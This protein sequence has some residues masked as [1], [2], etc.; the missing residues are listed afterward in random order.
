MGKAEINS[1]TLDPVV[2]Q[3][4]LLIGLLEPKPNEKD[5]Y[6]LNDRWFSDPW[7]YLQKIPSNPQMFTLMTTLMGSAAGNA[8][9]TP[10]Q[11]LNRTW[12][13]IMNTS[14]VEPKATGL[15]IVSGTP[16]G[17][18]NPEMGIGALYT[19]KYDNDTFSV[20]PYAYFP[21]FTLPDEAGNGFGFVLG[22]PGHPVQTGVQV[23]GGNGFFSTGKGINNL[24]FDGFNAG[25][26]IFFSEGMYPQL[27]LVFQNLRLPGE[28]QGVNRS[29]VDLI[30]NTSIQQWIT[31]ALSVLGSQLSQVGGPLGTAG[32][33]IHTLLELLGLL[34]TVPPVNWDAI[35][36]NPSDTG[37]VLSQWIRNIAVNPDSLK[38]WLNTWY[39]L[40]TGQDSS[41]SRD[42]ITGTGTRQDPFAAQVL[43]LEVTQTVVLYFDIGFAAVTGNDL[44]LSF[45]PNLIIRSKP[46]LPVMG[47]NTF[48]IDI[49]AQVELMAFT[50]PPAALLTDAPVFTLFP[51]LSLMAAAASTVAGKPLFAVQ[52]PLADIDSEQVFSIDS[53]QVGFTYDRSPDA[54]SDVPVPNFNL[55]NVQSAIGAWPVINLSSFS[56]EAFVNNI[57]SIVSNAISSFFGEN[58]VYAKAF[59]AVLGIAAPA[60]YSGEWP[61]KDQL[62]LSASELPLLIAN[63]FN[64]LG[65][66]YTRCLTTT[67]ASGKPLFTYLVPDICALLGGSGTTVLG[68]GTA[69]DPWRITVLTLGSAAM[70]FTSWY[71]PGSPTGLS[72][73]LAFDV[74]LVFTGVT[75]TSV[76]YAEL[77]SLQLP[78]ADGSGTWGAAWMQSALTRL[79]LTGTSGQVLSTPAL[80]GVALQC[81]SVTGEAGWKNS[82]GFYAQGTIRELLLKSNSTSIPLGTLTLGTT[83]WSEEQLKQFTPAI[84]NGLGLLLLENGGR[85]G[86][87]NAAILGLL[88]NMPEVINGSG[89]GYD[90]PVP[91]LALPGNWPVLS[92]T[93]YSDPWTDVQTQ[94]SNL[95]AGGSAMVIPALRMLGWGLTGEL[96]LQPAAQ[97]GNLYDPWEVQLA[98]A[99]VPL[100][101]LTWISEGNQ[102]GYG[103][104]YPLAKSS[105]AGVSIAASVRLDLPGFDLTPTQPLPPAVADEPVKPR[106]V[107]SC[108]IANTDPAQPLLQDNTTGLTIGSVQLG[109]S[110]AVSGDGVVYAPVFVFLNS[111]L[112]TGDSPGT[113]ELMIDGA[114]PQWT[115][116]QGLLQFNQLVY[117]LMNKLTDT[118]KA[119]AFAQ[120]DSLMKLLA[121][122]RIVMITEGSA[123]DAVAPEYGFNPGGW[124]AML[125]NP[126]A[127]FVQQANLVLNDPALIAGFLEAAAGVLGISPALPGGLPQVMAALGLFEQYQESYVPDFKN[128]LS[129]VTNPSE[130][131]SVH[132]K[133]LFADAEKIRSLVT[134]ISAYAGESGW[135]SIDSSGQIVTIGIQPEDPYVIGDELQLSAAVEIDLNA[136][137]LSLK[138]AVASVT[139]GSALEF[140]YAPVY[141]DAEFS[142]ETRCFLTSWTDGSLPAAFPPLQV[143]PIPEDVTAI[144]TQLGIQAPVTLLSTFAAKYLNTF[145]TPQNPAVLNLFRV[146][147]LAFADDTQPMRIRPLEGIFMHPVQWMLSP[148]V[149]GNGNG[150]IDLTRLGNLLYAVVDAAGISSGS[151]KLEPYEHEGKRDGVKLTGLPWGVN[152][153]LNSSETEGVQL[154]ATFAPGFSSPLPEIQLSGG[155][156]YIPAHGLSVSGTADLKFDFGTNGS[157]QPVA[158]EIQ[159]AYSRNVFTLSAITTTAGDSTIFQLLPFAG[160]NQFISGISKVLLETVG[161]MLFA[162]YDAYLVKNPNSALK[163]FVGSIESLTGITSGKTLYEFFNTIAGDPLAPFTPARIEGTISGIYTFV[164]GILQLD[165]FS[166]SENGN[167]LEYLITFD[168]FPQAKILM[169]VGIQDIRMD[170]RT[171]SA[172]GIWVQPTAQFEWITLGLSGTGVGVETPFNL[173]APNLV[174]AANFTVGINPSAIGIEGMPSPVLLFGL[175]GDL[176]RVYGPA[177]R[178]FPVKLSEASG[179]L[180]IDLLPECKLVITGN[181]S[182]TNTQWMLSFG[183]NFLVPLVANMALST[184]TVKGWLDNTTI[185]TVKG[186]PGKVLTDWG[187]LVKTGKGNYILNNLQ[188]AFDV[189]QPATIVTKLIFC[190]LNLI[191]GQC[192]VPIGDK[193]IYVQSIQ[194]GDLTRYGLRLQIPDIIVSGDAKP[195]SMK[196]IF[197]LGKYFGKETK[198]KNWTGLVS[199]PGLA[200]YFISRNKA[201]ELSFWPRFDLVSIGL[202]FSGPNA[203]KPLVDLNGVSIQAVEPRVLVILDLLDGH[204]TTNFG[205]AIML[206]TIGIPLGPGFANQGGSTNPVAQNLLTSGGSSDQTDAVNPAFSASAGYVYNDNTFTFQL[207][208]PDGNPTD[209]VILP[210]M[211]AFGPLQCRKIGIGWEKTPQLLDILFDGSVSL[212]GL[213]ADVQDLKIGIPVTTPTQFD[214]YKLDL[215]GLDISFKSGAVLISG[216]F[217]KDDSLGFIQYIGQAQIRTAQWGLGAFGAYGLVEGNVSLFIFAYLNAPIGGPPYFFIKG[218]SG[219][220]GYNR[221][222]NLPRADE[223][224]RF[225]LIAGID[226]SAALGGKNGNP[227]TNTEALSALGTTIVPP[228]LGSYWLAAGIKFTSFELIDSQAML[229][230]QFGTD[231]MIGLLGLSGLVL[232]KSGTPYVGAQ[233]AFTVTY[234]VS[235]GLLAMEAVLTPNSYVLSRDCRLTGGMAFYVWFKDQADTGA[236]AGEFVFTL[237][238]YS[239]KFNKPAYFPDEPRLG[240]S[241]TV[242]DVSIKGGAYF[243]LTPSAVMAGGSLEAVYKSGELRAWFNAWADFLIMWKPFHFYITVGINVGASYT[244]HFIWT[245]TFKVELGA[246]LEL[247]GPQTAG[248]VKVKWWV[249]SFTVKFG[250][251]N[252]SKQG[253]RTIDWPQFKE[254]F[255]PKDQAPNPPPQQAPVPDG[256]T[257]VMAAGETPKVQQVT[258]IRALEGLL[259]E[260][261]DAGTTLWQVAADQFVFAVSTVAPLN[262]VMYDNNDQQKIVESN[263]EFGLR[264]LG[265]VTFNGAD[266]GK[267]S[268]LSVSILMNSVALPQTALNFTGGFNGV[269]YSLWGTVNNGS[270]APDSKIIPGALVGLEAVQVI[271]K[272][273]PAGPPKFPVSNF[274]LQP[275]P[276]RAL[277]LWN[278]PALHPAEPARHSP[279]SVIII[280]QTIMTAPVPEKRKAILEAVLAS[281]INVKTDGNLSMMAAYASAVFQSFPML[282][283]LGSLGQAPVQQ[284]SKR[285][286]YVNGKPARTRS[287]K[288]KST[289]T[290]SAPVVRAYTLQYPGPLLHTNVFM[291][292]SNSDVKQMIPVKGS[293]YLTGLLS[294]AEDHAMLKGVTASSANG[295]TSV[296]LLPGS[297]VMIDFNGEEMPA[298]V[299]G[300]FPVYCAFFDKNNQYLSS[301]VKQPGNTFTIS[302]EATQSLFFGIDTANLTLPYAY[303]WHSTTQ[304]IQVNPNALTGMGAII[305]PQ[306]PALIPA[307]RRLRDFGLIQGSAMLEQNIVETLDGIVNGSVLTLLPAGLKTV[308][309]LF[310][311]E[312]AVTEP[313]TDDVSATIAV[314]QDGKIS[315][316]PLEAYALV[317]GLY[318]NAVI[319]TLP[320]Q[321]GVNLRTVAAKGWRLTGVMALT[322]DAADVYTNWEAIVL[323]PPVPDDIDQYSEKTYVRLGTE[324]AAAT[325][326]GRK[327]K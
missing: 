262:Y 264:P 27:N 163:L 124:D 76:T 304:L 41:E 254:Y 229:V 159:T 40:F 272:Q 15:Y 260:L 261:D 170:S 64:A 246:E 51:G 200:A 179:T 166:I 29:I 130:Y 140:L 183:T 94:L 168:K 196:L 84:V 143:W 69:A 218:L 139:L 100:S 221:A 3:I 149:I 296:E 52:N 259:H 308:C 186:L 176:N 136:F 162:A 274:T 302:A 141:K 199:E 288:T 115:S 257:R 90:F 79:I 154:S 300:V 47:M 7:T 80:A 253:P 228:Q 110:A 243:A 131:L 126:G 114:G 220:F 109:F 305:I 286:V 233:M 134:S 323:K 59:Q 24:S 315:F 35:V 178:L 150:G 81:L 189:S 255:L 310:T 313:A 30:E 142:G 212:A 224:Y 216:G 129:L 156:A 147:G 242:G 92:V 21:L 43:K 164:S 287:R 184:D 36:Q 234:R 2:I 256:T 293:L 214:K 321:Q 86:V 65:A 61:L 107:A 132:V 268:A 241:W 138:A 26:D 161:D 297:S 281:G 295:I 210:I 290:L 128:L 34:G 309:V 252:V 63:P 291:A 265:S 33:M 266:S 23:N 222:I 16:E 267:R 181:P 270:T 28:K 191:D 248:S 77:L 5:V 273:M 327:K 48:G 46:I 157:G 227:P 145:A 14:G 118:L 158:F 263:A 249:I 251:Q 226:N 247:W 91:A 312:G 258:Q 148:S 201:G 50:T 204:V 202:D 105:S 317:K 240:F 223:V 99:P 62:L 4:G 195:G 108:T 303:G 152:F 282:G 96:P 73:G 6:L 25:A 135:F 20:L 85:I 111:C 180:V 232:P 125:A 187:L 144:V 151:V 205:A 56:E 320:D 123:T 235:T 188:E 316:V 38:A 98:G 193:G 294:S 175:S 301:S 225:P 18:T 67:D 83:D 78:A 326:P 19:W 318:E 39:C 244:V 160:L 206:D 208:N 197:Q 190:A 11:A 177:L 155:V 87:A 192:V 113:F 112:K 133:R 71:N 66:Y 169:Q 70:Q 236:S 57:G 322:E 275:L 185:G 165:G 174:Y 283:S 55:V 101:L 245:T 194:Q 292:A 32:K 31:T 37:R 95:Y 319:Y 280:E 88:P 219:G 325:N 278:D 102:A 68:D 104:R 122:L 72:L 117:P 289:V 17:Q 277:T 58:N 239:N 9:G 146:M 167:Y 173:A 22:Q 137:S 269:P 60:G 119:G 237:G 213:T 231:F 198:D 121:D 171:V 285:R 127:Y 45:Y 153:V 217:L 44:M 97:Q 306:S 54:V 230:V 8:L 215:A 279:E 172:F 13:P 75:A 299:D 182:A 82:N 120:L 314:E 49:R 307:G 106:F 211:R 276:D 324:S 298:S 89:T 53:M 42:N 1:Q 116:P 250:D 209:M 93:N 103:L 311:A 12:Y 284:K 203:Q 271:P 238:G 10:T 74:P 207:Y